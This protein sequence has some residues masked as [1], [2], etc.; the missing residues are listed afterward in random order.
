MGDPVNITDESQRG[1]SS[2]ISRGNV[3]VV[4]T[5]VYCVAFLLGTL[6]NG[7]VVYVTGFKMKQTVNI[8]WFLNLAVADFLFTAFLLFDI[9]YIS[10]GFVWPFGDFICKLNTLVGV[11]NMFTSVFLLMVISL[12]RCLLTWLAVWAQ[13]KRTICKAKVI[14]ITIWLIS[15]GCSIPYSAYKQVFQ[16][17]NST[18]C[19][20]PKITAT[21]HR[22]LIIFRSVVGFFI[23]FVIILGSYLA[24]SKR[25]ISLQRKKKLKPFRIIL[26]VILAFFLCWLPFHIFQYLDLK[27]NSD[28]NFSG[29]LCKAVSVGVPLSTSVAFLNSC[30]N[31]VLYVFLCEDFQQ[32]FHQ[33]IL[34][35]LESTF[36]EEHLFINIGKNKHTQAKPLNQDQ[37]NETG[38]FLMTQNN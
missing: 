24:I 4:A 19:G 23:P 31:P 28:G 32:R 8:I 26:A 17:K 11:L 25:I 9:V 15:L 20:A 38:A 5:V 21:I 16:Y 34:S 2:Y 1:N 37:I 10:R 30:L 33:S 7:L 3:Q 13:N 6:G 22:D 14:C 36:L 12:D 27:C 35:V 18:V 29:A